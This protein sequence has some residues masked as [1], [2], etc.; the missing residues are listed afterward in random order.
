[1]IEE[2][3]LGMKVFLMDKEMVNFFLIL[4]NLGYYERFILG[5]KSMLVFI[6]FFCIL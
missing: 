1:M 6:F 5:V 4:L 3:G 2:S